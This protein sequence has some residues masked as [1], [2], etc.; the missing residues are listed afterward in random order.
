MGVKYPSFNEEPVHVCVN[1]KQWAS[2]CCGTFQIPFGTFKTVI[3]WPYFEM[4]VFTMHRKLDPCKYLKLWWK[5]LDMNF[6]RWE[7]YISF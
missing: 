1:G 4:S 2:N 6:K 5:I 3:L 7:R